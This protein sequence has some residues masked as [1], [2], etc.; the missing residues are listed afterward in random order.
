MG[1]DDVDLFD[2][3]GKYIGFAQYDPVRNAYFKYDKNGKY[4]GQ[5][6]KSWTGDIVETDAT[7]KYTGMTYTSSLG[8]TKT[9]S[10]DGVLTGTTRK[11]YSFGENNTYSKA[12]P[13]ASVDS[14]EI[15]SPKMKAEQKVKDKTIT[16]I[17]CGFISVQFIILSFLN[18]GE[19]QAFSIAMSLIF[20]V[21]A[22]M[23]LNSRME[24]GKKIDNGENSS[25]EED[26]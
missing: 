11:T 19:D 26:K 1:K 8:G 10:K 2:K 3:N 15:P 18:E 16:S 24:W 21:I 23:A 25:G 13:S 4:L 9:Y 6:N 12:T 20:F 7:G 17:L 22:A 14:S 5:A